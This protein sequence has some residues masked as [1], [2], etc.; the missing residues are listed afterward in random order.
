MSVAVKNGTKG[1]LVVPAAVPRKAGFKSGQELEFRASG[2]VTINTLRNIDA[3]QV[4]CV[5]GR[6]FPV[7]H[8]CQT[9]RT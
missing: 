3:R 1:P 2:G 9:E 7:L 4:F 5:S 8:P 6:T